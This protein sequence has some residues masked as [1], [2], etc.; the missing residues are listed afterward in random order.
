MNI[1]VIVVFSVLLIGALT[2]AVLRRPSKIEDVD[3]WGTR[4]IENARITFKKLDLNIIPKKEYKFCLLAET[5]ETGR[6][7][8]LHK[9]INEFIAGSGHTI[10][11]AR[12]DYENKIQWQFYTARP[13]A[14]EKLIN[15][16]TLQVSLKIGKIEDPSWSEYLFHSGK[17]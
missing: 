1:E 16:I 14:A 9:S 5:E 6:N 11:T 3:Y 7:I 2:Y 10:L 12:I 4:N 15:K 17:T 13:L 8:S